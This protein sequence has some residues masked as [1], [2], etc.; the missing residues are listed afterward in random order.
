[1]TI[2]ILLSKV[3]GKQKNENKSWNSICNVVG[4]R[5]MKMESQIPFSNGVGKRETKLEV[6]I[7]F[8]HI[9][10]KRLALRYT[11]FFLCCC[12]R[13]GHVTSKVISGSFGF[14]VFKCF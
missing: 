1:M 13:L 4:K 5:K 9:V 8:S 11:H 14:I 2:R 12:R 7:P 10:G 6:Q 3:V